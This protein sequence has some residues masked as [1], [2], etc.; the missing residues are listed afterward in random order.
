MTIKFQ[1]RPDDKLVQYAT[2]MSRALVL[3]MGPR[4]VQPYRAK[5]ASYA[6][7][8]KALRGDMQRVGQHIRLAMDAIKPK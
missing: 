2:G 8:A 7:D 1:S 5:D 6:A 4:R 3:R